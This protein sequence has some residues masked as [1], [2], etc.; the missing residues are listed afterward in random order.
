MLRL[1]GWADFVSQHVRVLVRKVHLAN[2]NKVTDAYLPFAEPRGWLMRG[3]RKRHTC[4]CV[5]ARVQALI[6]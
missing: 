1:F 6:R 4:C 2:G 3:K 5:P